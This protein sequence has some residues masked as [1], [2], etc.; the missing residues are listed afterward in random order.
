MEPLGGAFLDQDFVINPDASPEERNKLKCL[1]VLRAKISEI[2]HSGEFKGPMKGQFTKIIKEIRKNGFENL[3]N[4][5]DQLKTILTQAGPEAIK[6][7]A[8]SAKRARHEQNDVEEHEEEEEIPQLEAIDDDVQGPMDIE[9]REP[10]EA[11]QAQLRERVRRLRDQYYHPV[12]RVQRASEHVQEVVAE[13]GE[14]VKEAVSKLGKTR[15]LVVIGSVVGSLVDSAMR[16]APA[17]VNAENTSQLLGA[18]VYTAARTVVV[19][20]GVLAVA[21][22]SLY[23]WNRLAPEAPQ[24][25]PKEPAKKKNKFGI[26]E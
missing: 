14:Q 5:V 17:F 26:D 8:S 3:A 13:K 10:V 25:Q 1:N 11:A 24:E 16:A 19:A 4:E 22:S 6:S 9:E 21:A 12:A 20:G 7:A 23:A 15:A 18:S 2:E